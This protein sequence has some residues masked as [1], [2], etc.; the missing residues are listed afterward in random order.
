[1]QQFINPIAGLDCCIPLLMTNRKHSLMTYR[2]LARRYRPQSLHDVVGQ[3]DL[4]QALEH[5]LRTGRTA[6]GFLFHGIRGVGKT[7][8]A[9]IL[10]KCFNCLGPDGVNTLP[11]PNPCDVCVSCKAFL[12][13]R[14]L[15]VV[16]IDAASNTG[17]DDIREI[18]E[19]ARYKAVQGR[20]KI[21]IIDEVHMLSKNAFNA[22]LKT[23]E[24][25]PPHVVFILATTELHKIPDT[26][27]SRCQR[28][29][30]KKMSIDTLIKRMTFIMDL[31]QLSIDEKALNLI[32]RAADG[33]MRDSLSLLDQAIVLSLGHLAN[34]GVC[35]DTVERMLG[36]SAQ[37]H[38]FDVLELVI[39]AQATELMAKLSHI[40][41]EGS[42]PLILA[43]EILDH[44]YWVVLM[45]QD[46]SLTKNLSWPQVQRERGHAIADSI[47]MGILLGM[48]Q[49]LVQGYEEIKKSPNPSQALQIMLLRV[50][51][52]KTLTPIGDLELYEEE[53]L[54]MPLVSPLSP[55]IIISTLST[56]AQP[57]ITTKLEPDVSHEKNADSYATTF[58][59]I[60]DLL[61]TNREM[62]LL[63]QIESHIHFI[64]LEGLTLTLRLAQGGPSSLGTLLE[65][66]L[67][68]LTNQPWKVVLNQEEGG[69]ETLV[70]K[71]QDHRDFVERQA[72]NHPVIKD[73]MQILPSGTQISV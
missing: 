12:Q 19:S 59:F 39:N 61:D 11:T 24:E 73:L 21:F 44:L 23:L 31:E 68:K 28:F 18:I 10:A 20:Y 62:L 13:D 9:R 34:Q 3:P 70:K 37:D 50:C 53:K 16:E 56:A 25:P 42:D 69:Q 14:H 1:M 33:S 15:D 46:P 65:K 5:A 63:Q 48:W 7:T 67:K 2:A 58:E 55:P 41:F 35:G 6:Q 29:D 54:V 26:I 36:F 22:L 71:R 57:V 72:K 32:A 4:V 43:S 52:I 60:T 64:K 27:L 17:V 66:K 47:S 45:K 40:L 49:V 8:T 30:L 38:L 51:Y